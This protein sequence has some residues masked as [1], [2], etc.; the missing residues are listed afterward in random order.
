M[1]GVGGEDV[2]VPAGNVGAEAVG[3]GN[4]GGGLLDGL[5]GVEPWGHREDCLPGVAEVEG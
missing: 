5:G 4:K 1:F 3:D 2:G